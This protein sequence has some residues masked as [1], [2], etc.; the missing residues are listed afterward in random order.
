M[1]PPR[2]VRPVGNAMLPFYIMVST[3]P[4]RRRGIAE[5]G[6]TPTAYPIPIS[7]SR[8]ARLRSKEFPPLEVAEDMRCSLLGAPTAPTF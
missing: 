2:K 1:R 7:T 6:A 5:H 8:M 4:P 3:E